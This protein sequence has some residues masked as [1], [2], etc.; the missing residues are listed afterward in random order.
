VW[1]I[2]QWRTGNRELG[3]LV[4]GS[5]G[6]MTRWAIGAE[7]RPEAW[8]LGLD[9]EASYTT[10]LDDLYI[11]NRGSFLSALTLEAEL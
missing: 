6:W 10:Y 5:F 8:V 3:P 9:L 11:T 1:Q 7:T 2:P 4:I